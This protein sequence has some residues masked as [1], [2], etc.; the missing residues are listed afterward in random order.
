MVEKIAVIKLSLK[1]SKH[2]AE[3]LDDQHE[4]AGNDQILLGATPAFKFKL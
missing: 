3:I 2:I 1:V 4:W